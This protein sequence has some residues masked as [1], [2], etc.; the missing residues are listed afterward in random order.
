MTNLIQKVASMMRRL[1]NLETRTAT[2]EETYDDMV[3]RLVNLEN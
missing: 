3:R 2:L 1:L